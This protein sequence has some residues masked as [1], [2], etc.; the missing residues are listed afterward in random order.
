MKCR[1][2]YRTDGTVAIVQLAP[3]ARRGGESDQ[4]FLNRVAQKATRDSEIKNPDGSTTVVPHPLKGLPFDDMDQAALPDMATIDKWRGDKTTGLRVDSSVVTLA[5]RRQVVED[6]LD[7][8]YVKPDLDV[9]T[10]LRLQRQLD[11]G[12]F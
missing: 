6:A 2:I 10:T 3:K 7:A 5:E 4:D 11:T 12:N 8:E 1:V 9:E